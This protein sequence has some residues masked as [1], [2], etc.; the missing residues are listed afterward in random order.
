ML[1]RALLPLMAVVAAA[2]DEPPDEAPLFRASTRLVDLHISVL[3][4]DGNLRTDIPES[5]FQVSENGV[6][7]PVKRFRREDVPVTMGILIDNSG[8]MRDKRSRVAAAAL[9]LIKDSNPSDEVFIV[10]FNDRPFLDQGLTNDIRKLEAALAHINARGGTA[11]RDAIS[12]SADWI[13]DHG[14][15]D[16]KVLVVITDGNDNASEERLEQLVRKVRR[17]EVLVYS[18]T[19]LAEERPHDAR[20]ARKAMKT[21]AEASGGLDYYPRT[22]AEVERIAPEIAHE[23]RNQYLL[24]YSPSNQV[25]DG[26]FRRIKVLVNGLGRVTVRT[27]NGYYATPG[28]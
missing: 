26:S 14:H 20:E 11:M 24:E 6:P 27:R 15:R 22:L 5:A 4:K 10:N 25:L 16:K 9:A 19:L 3:D 7:Q 18:I 17:S 13:R 8:S 12:L 28:K 1:L 2:Q 21:L 23:I